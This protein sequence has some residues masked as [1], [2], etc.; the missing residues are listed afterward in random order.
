MKDRQEPR[1]VPSLCFLVSKH[2]PMNL[3]Q[4]Q[5]IF[6]SALFLF[7]LVI[8]GAACCGST[9]CCRCKGGDL[10][11][12]VATA[13]IGPRQCCCVPN[14]GVSGVVLASL[15]CTD[16]ASNTSLTVHSDCADWGSGFRHSQYGLCPCRY[17]CPLSFRHLLVEDSV[18]WLAPQSLLFPGPCPRV[19]LHGGLEYHDLPC[20]SISY[21]A[22]KYL[23]L[24]CSCVGKFMFR[25]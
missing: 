7:Q 16:N 12:S 10:C 2:L 14:A 15:T 21:K 19:A 25:G 6:L 23:Q 13:S 4:I 17:E 1:A 24:P 8:I 22:K 11:A 18:M 20:K 5:C 3:S 9:M